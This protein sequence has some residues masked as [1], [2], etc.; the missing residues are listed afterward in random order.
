MKINAAALNATLASARPLRPQPP[1]PFR[2]IERSP[3]KKGSC[4]EFKMFVRPHD[5]NDTNT[6]TIE[7][8]HFR[9]GPPEHWIET[10][11]DIQQVITG[12]RIDTAAGSFAIVRTILKGDALRLFEDAVTIHGTANIQRFNRCMDHVTTHIFPARALIYQKRY[13]S[14]DMCKPRDVSIRDYVIRV[15]ELNAL[16]GYFPPFGENQELPDDE[17][18]DIVEHNIPATWQRNMLIQGWDPVLHT[19]QDLQ[20]FC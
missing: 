2:K 12:S 14:H 10:I 7:V 18:V 4:T 19:L 11:N 16:L 3:P 13:L 1:I 5:V 20:E 6:Y 17:I 9:T 15:H 8:P